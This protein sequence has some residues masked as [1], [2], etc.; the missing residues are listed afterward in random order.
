MGLAVK[1]DGI[2]VKR[3]KLGE[4]DLILTVL[5]TEGDLFQ[6]ILKGARNPKSK[7]VGKAELLSEQSFLL[8]SARSLPII[9]ESSIINSHKALGVD[10]NLSFASSVIAEIAL[11]TSMPDNPHPRFFELT[12]A[13]L[14]ALENAPRAAYVILAA[15]FV[16]ALALHGYQ[17]VINRC[18]YCF[19]ELPLVAWSHA[20]GGALC[21]NCAERFDYEPYSPQLFAWIFH[22]LMSTFDE[23]IAEDVS[24]EAL[25]DATR[26]LKSYFEYIYQ[27]PLKS[28]SFFWDMRDPSN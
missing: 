6:G 11:K 14:S 26:L 24:V 20:A 16:K 15:Y 27:T 5:S 10:F 7:T 23:L 3:T 17:P 21:S 4:T 2:V 18:A 1:R 22:L 9:T 19:E 28:L 25:D 8:S 13:A 12:S